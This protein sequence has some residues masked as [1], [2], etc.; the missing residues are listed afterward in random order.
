MYMNFQHYTSLM[1]A[2]IFASCITEA[3]YANW[4]GLPNSASSAAAQSGIGAALLRMT[5]E[6]A[7]NGGGNPAGKMRDDTALKDDALPLRLTIALGSAAPL[8]ISSASSVRSETQPHSS[9]SQALLEKYYKGAYREVGSEG[10]LLLET[11]PHNRE[12]RYI[13]ANSL[14]WTGFSKDALAQYEALA[15]TDYHDRALLGLGNVNRWNGRPDRAEAAYREILRKEPDNEEAGNGFLFTRRDL[16]PRTDARIGR[17]GNSNNAFRTWTTLGHSWRNDTGSKISELSVG[18]IEENKDAL[19]LVQRDLSFRYE[20]LDAPLAPQMEISAQEAPHAK[21]F[22][23]LTLK[24]GDT[25]AYI[26]VAHIN[27]GKHAFDPSALRDGLTANLLGAKANFRNTFGELRLVYNAYQVSDGNLVQGANLHFTPSLQPFGSSSIKG[28]FGV[29]ARKARFNDS[30]Y[31]SPEEGYYNAYAGIGAD[32]SNVL[33]QT[34]GSI[35]Y[36]LPLT[37]ESGKSWSAGFGVKR[38]LGRNWAMGFD[39]WAINTPRDGGYKS[40]SGTLRIE[41]LW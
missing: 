33:W 25:P 8:P 24:V 37:G 9:A 40:T 10:L 34:Y 26:D 4:S 7:S 20:D 39:L 15:G 30:R 32:W 41:K 17:A 23:A 6:L 12:L 21:L 13:V 18:R 29:E 19:R 16:R 2:G 36:G 3:A 35:K 27:W 38:W 31:W 5:M 14:A 28:F 11:E 1:A 22:G